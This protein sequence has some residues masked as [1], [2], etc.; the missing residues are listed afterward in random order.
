LTPDDAA[1]LSV[2][3]TL[4]ANAN[5]LRESIDLLTS[6]IL[7]ERLGSAAART[8][9]RWLY[10]WNLCVTLHHLGEDERALAEARHGRELDPDAIALIWIQTRPLAGLGRLDEIEHV[11]EET[12]QTPSSAGPYTH[13]Q[14][15][16]HVACELRWHGHREAGIKMA[17]RA[18]EW[19]R[20]RPADEIAQSRARFAMAYSLWVAERWDEARPL[21][22]V[23]LRENPEDED[24][25]GALGVVAARSGNRD[26]V[27]RLD[28]ELA[29]P[30][31][32]GRP[33]RAS[34]QRAAIAAHLG[35]KER[36]VRLL[37]EATAEGLQVEGIHG[38]F[39]MLPLVG[40]PPFE[41]LMRPK[42]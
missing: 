15:M 10:Y 41:V 24:L 18:I 38:D 39:E 26:E 11:V 9:R 37:R 32:T 7:R 35:D 42:D 25:A 4:A 30:G 28:D 40:Y 22:A 17:N 12:L 31:K 34:Y 23:L 21:L 20:A 19:L 6:P 5:H 8:P 16:L 33:G 1:S 27:L 29:R 13:G 14:L 3:A 36:A 2:L